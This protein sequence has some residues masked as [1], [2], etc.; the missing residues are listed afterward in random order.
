MT[1]DQWRGHLPS[2]IRT[3]SG[4]VYH[5]T[6]SAGLLGLVENHE[7]W[8]TEA[9][10]MNDVAEVRQGWD[11]IRDWLDDQPRDPVSDIMRRAA[12]PAHEH[13]AS[14]VDGI[15]FSCASTRPD[16]ANQWRLYGG[17]G[18]GYAV[19][20]DTDIPLVAMARSESRPKKAPRR[21][22][23]RLRFV[24]LGNSASVS[25]WLHVLYTDSE[26]AQA[27]AGLLKKASNWWRSRRAR[28]FDDE[29]ARNLEG[30]EFADGL[31]TDLARVAQLMKSEGF[32]GENEVRVIAT[33][34]LD[35][36]SRFRPTQ[37]GV[38]RYLRLTGAPADYRGHEEIVYERELT[39]KTIPIES[40][41][42]GPLINV[43][44][45]EQTIR[46]LLHRNGFNGRDIHRSAVPLGR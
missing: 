23:G 16:D 37:S 9:T 31:V 11:F 12:D 20:I 38:V 4:P 21:P 46:A 2:T 19:G 40:V 15:F 32:E 28:G 29:E 24:T 18:H 42:M 45:N 10:G 44:N 5:Y 33:V 8:A 22:P 14:R 26:K 27:L 1:D 13:P 43:Q 41:R 39:A 7:L 35:G 6:D 25:P 3:A 17:A 36:C 34:M 30:Q